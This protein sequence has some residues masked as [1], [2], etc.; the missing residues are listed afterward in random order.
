MA[1]IEISVQ[2][3]LANRLG[4]TA[5]WSD[6]T[7]D[8]RVS[9]VALPSFQ[10]P[11]QLEPGE[12]VFTIGSCFARNIERVLASRGFR[13]P[14]LDLLRQPQFR[15]VNPAI[16]NNYGVPSIY[17][18]FSWALDPEARFD[19]RANFIEVSPG[20][21]AD[22]HVVATERPRPFEELALRRNAIIEATGTVIDCRAVIVT[23]GLTELWYDHLQG[24]YLNSTPML[25]V[26][27]ADP[28]RFSLRVLDFGETLGFM[29]RSI[30]LLQSRC[31]RDQQIILTVSPVPLINTFRQDMDVMVANSYS[32]SCLR[33]VA[34]HI[35]TDYAH[36]HY[37]PSYESVT[38][39]DRKVAWLDD[40]VHVTD[41]I[42]RINVDRMVRAYCPPDDSMAALDEAAQTG[43]ALALLEEAKKH[44]VGDKA[45]GLA[46]FERF[47][48]LS[49]ESPDFAEEAVKF[50]IRRQM[51]QKA[52]C[53]LDHIPA[54][55][56]PN[57]RALRM[58]QIH[59]LSQNYAPVPG[60]LEPYI[61]HGAKLALQ[62]RMLILAYVRLDEIGKAR[63][64][65]LDWLRSLPGDEYDALCALGDAFCDAFPAEAVA[66]YDK[67]DALKELD[68]QRRLAWIECLIQSGAR[69]RARAALEVFDSQDPYQVAA[70]NRLAAIL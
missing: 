24:I 28:D 68:V 48:A 62:R 6:G 7:A 64:A 39:S 13:L 63:R 17:N 10:A 31:R 46:F 2:Q 29:R 20:K 49:A 65:V 1:L 57:L 23:L 55:W 42:V 61:V 58:A 35:C 19:Q 53:H 14:M 26:L 30:D 27:K 5:G 40:N 52:R 51:P 15:T 45:P 70:H 50:Y 18:D 25:R 38:L 47:S 41:D 56:H 11:F 60:L 21:C 16:I 3:A 37:F 32:K 54:D 36:V 12:K 9:P 59:V 8:N 34:E 44:A 22:L 33:T 69:D 66:A 43:G 4:E 67:A